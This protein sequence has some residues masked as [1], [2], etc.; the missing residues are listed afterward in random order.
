MSRASSDGRDSV[1]IAQRA[2]LVL[3]LRRRS[4]ASGTHCRDSRYVIPSPGGTC[5]LNRF[6]QA[7]LRNTRM[8]DSNTEHRTTYRTIR[9][10]RDPADGLLPYHTQ[11]MPI[12]YNTIQPNI[13]SS[14]TE[15]SSLTSS[16]MH[17]HLT[18]PTVTLTLPHSIHI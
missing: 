3:V 17:K 1:T 13:R 14:T 16:H 18:H 6:Q 9:V 11:P 10:A 8:S 2:S 5:K 7:M 4:K 15:I 12:H